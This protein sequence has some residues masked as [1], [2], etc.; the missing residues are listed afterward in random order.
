[1]LAMV[2]SPAGSKRK[3][4]GHRGWKTRIS[5]EQDSAYRLLENGHE[6]GKPSKPTKRGERSLRVN[7]NFPQLRDYGNKFDLCRCNITNL[8]RRGQGG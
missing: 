2:E 1:M 4:E 5:E 7:N 3:R 6:F 8:S